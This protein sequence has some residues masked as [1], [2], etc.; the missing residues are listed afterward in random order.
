[1]IRHPSIKTSSCLS[2]ILNV[3]FVTSNQ[4][5]DIFTL[6][7][8]TTTN[9]VLIVTNCITYTVHRLHEGTCGTGLLTWVTAFGFEGDVGCKV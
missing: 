1:M 4:V 2:N 6:T 5:N 7:V 9:F 8:V 3:T